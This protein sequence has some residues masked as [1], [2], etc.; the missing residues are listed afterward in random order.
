MKSL[1]KEDIKLLQDVLDYDL[2]NNFAT[3]TQYTSP[4]QALRNQ[5]DALEAKEKRL[6]LFK[7]LVEALNN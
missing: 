1:T 4:A 2:F 7:E 5:A 3:T 6:Q